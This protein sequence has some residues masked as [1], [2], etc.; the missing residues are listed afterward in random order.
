MINRQF[1]LADSVSK[2]HVAEE[3][4]RLVL[5]RCEQIESGLDLSFT[6]VLLPMIIQMTNNL[7]LGK[8]LDVGCG[9]GFVTRK[10]A[11]SSKNIIGIDISEVSV[12]VAKKRNGK[13]KNIQFLHSSVEQFSA[14]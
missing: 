11:E 6:N 1:R 13:V 2:D 7:D 8:V 5:L 14:C 3:W 10:I 12:E 4:N 9:A